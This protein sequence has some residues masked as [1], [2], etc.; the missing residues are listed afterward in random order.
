MSTSSRDSHALCLSGS[1]LEKLPFALSTIRD[2]H[3]QQSRWW[4][5]PEKKFCLREN[6]GAHSFPASV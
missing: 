5:C 1:G 2:E 3:H 4:K 6:Q